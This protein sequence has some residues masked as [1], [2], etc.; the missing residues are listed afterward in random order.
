MLFEEEDSKM[1][2]PKFGFVFRNFGFVFGL[3][4]LEFGFGITG[5]SLSVV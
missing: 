4:D 2:R 3:L 5:N 1:P